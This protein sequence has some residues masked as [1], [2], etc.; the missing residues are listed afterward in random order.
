MLIGRSAFDNSICDWR[1]DGTGPEEWRILQM[2]P[3]Q[4]SLRARIERGALE[5]QAQ[6][7]GLRSASERGV[8]DSRGNTARISIFSANPS[9]AAD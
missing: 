7:R 8:S 5:R 1:N 9:R 2:G 4:M 3:L 6:T